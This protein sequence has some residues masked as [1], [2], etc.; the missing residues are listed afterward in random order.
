V[1]LA[2]PEPDAAARFDASRRRMLVGP[3][4]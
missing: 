4:P 2:R 1:S 3:E